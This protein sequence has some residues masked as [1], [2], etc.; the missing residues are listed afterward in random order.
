MKIRFIINPISGTGKQK[1][2][3]EIVKKYFNF[4]NYDFAYTNKK[5][6]ASVL[7]KSAINENVNIIVAVEVMDS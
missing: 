5:G 3:A 2:I 4:E 1:N 6:H 7:C